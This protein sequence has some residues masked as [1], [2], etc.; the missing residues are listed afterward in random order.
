MGLAA[1]QDRVAHGLMF[2]RF[3]A[4][5]NA[6]APA[7]S[8]SAEEFEGILVSCGLENFLTP[9]EWMWRLAAGKLE[10]H[11]R[12]V[13]FDDGL[14]SQLEVA[15]PVL[16]AYGLKAFWFIY[17]CVF[18]GEPV[19]GEIYSHVI[20][21]VGG[22]DAIVERLRAA[23]P[24]LFDRM[25]QPA[26]ERY[27]QAIR[28]AAPFYSESDVVFRF[29]RNSPVTRESLD[30]GMKKV[31][32]DH[33]CSTASLAA[34]LWM[35]NDDLK[36]LSAAG[37]HVGLH[38]YSHPYAMASLSREEQR[39]EYETN[40]EHIAS[41]CQVRPR[42]A[43]HPLNSYNS[44]SLAVLSALNIECAFRANL[45]SPSEGQAK[46]E[47]PREDC[48]NLLRPLNHHSQETGSQ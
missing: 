19:K 2:H 11:H 13:T 10:P 36:A 38:S 35:E 29:L 34:E 31:M 41:V 17:S 9:D 30:A 27:S 8:I 7:G 42:A 24:E 32:E 37:H 5:G 6:P 14:R 46:L 21:R 45:Q 26:L 28:A 3:R 39:R 16:N 40:L 12:C 4:R 25:D 33:G 22:S 20:E 47:L 43:S 15:L 18:F 1:S 23:A 48:A 44:D